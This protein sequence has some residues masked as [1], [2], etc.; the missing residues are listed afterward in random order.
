MVRIFRKLESDTLHLPELRPFIGKTVEITVTEQNVAEIT[1]GTGD[2]AKA[3]KAAQALR[4]AG[5]DFDAWRQQREVD[6]NHANE[7][8]V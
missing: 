8:L 2:W 5:Y 4:E 7:H 3:E 6:A 1:P